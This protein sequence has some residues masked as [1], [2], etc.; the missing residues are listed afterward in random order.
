MRITD[1]DELRHVAAQVPTA[2]LR[3]VTN[4][5]DAVLVAK[6]FGRCGA[7]QDEIEILAGAIEG[8]ARAWRREQHLIEA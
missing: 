1:I 6:R 2:Y 7:P 5:R 3:G 8:R 4:H